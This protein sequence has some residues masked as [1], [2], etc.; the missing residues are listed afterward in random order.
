MGGLGA[1]SHQLQ[2]VSNGEMQAHLAIVDLDR[3][4]SHPEYRHVTKPTT[5]KVFVFDIV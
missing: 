2:Y 5:I 1:S 4:V 3:N